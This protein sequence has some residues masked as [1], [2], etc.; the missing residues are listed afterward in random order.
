[1]QHPLEK[2][3]SISNHNFITRMENKF[4]QEFEFH[5]AKGLSGGVQKNKQQVY[6]QS[7]DINGEW[8]VEVFRFK[9]RFISEYEEIEKEA[10]LNISNKYQSYK[11]ATQREKFI[12]RTI[13][14]LDVLKNK[15]QGLSVNQKHKRYH[16]LLV[17]KIDAFSNS[18]DDIYLQTIQTEDN[19]NPKIRW[20]A[21]TKVLTTLFYDLI[22]GQKGKGRG[23]EDTVHFIRK[24]RNINALIKKLLMEN[25]LDQEGNALKSG[26]IQSYLKDPLG[27]GKRI[28]LEYKKR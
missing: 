15:I 23:V 16:E 24:Q 2:Y 20:S 26:T 18:L 10:Y 5:F 3:R 6:I 22:H 8:Q 27:K 28:E 7:E 1:M 21:D 14:E 4:Y 11:N 13:A 19:S 25:F 9:S 17:K 12:E